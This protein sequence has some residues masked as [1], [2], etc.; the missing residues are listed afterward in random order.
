MSN[1][2]IV[3][4]SIDAYERE[5]VAL[6]TLLTS[7]PAMAPE[8]GG[9]GELIKA[10]ALTEWLKKNG[11]TDIVRYDAK[12]SRV[13]SGIRPN[14]V[15]TIKGKSDARRLW[16][17]SHLDVVP[18]GDRSMW[19]SDPF[20]VVEKDGK[21]YGRGVEDNQQGLVSGVFAALA[22]M[23][24]NIVP[25]HTIK[26]LFVADE[27]VGSKF[28]IQHLLDNEK[29]FQ[30]DD[31]IIIPDGGAHDSSEIEVAEKNLM[32]LKITTKGKQC[33]GSVPDEGRNAF[34]AAC[35]LALKVNRL[36][37]EKFNAHNPLFNPDRSTFS[38]TKKEAN[39]PNIN[40]IPGDDVFYFDCRILPEYPNEVVLTEIK[41]LMAETE[42]VHGVTMTVE[43][44]Q[45]VESRP[46][47]KDADVVKALSAAVKE[48]YGVTAKPI[49]IGGGTVGAY[50]RNAGYDCVV[51]SRLDETA[52]Q[53]NECAQ[54]ANIKGD[55]RV[56]ASLMLLA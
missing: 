55:A 35:D 29:L 50:L 45:A 48:V 40:T 18:E 23:R 28:G 26:L 7:I 33:H 11:I 53:P 47:P 44:A 12:D 5:I 42:K 56:L 31:F 22:L 20:T 8:S 14:M 16:I 13:E 30:K 24:N 41:R 43:L 49:G 1:K 19:K 38:P 46:T 39:V 10:E 9:Q 52:H 27:E 15:A 6:E 51:W 3:F 32:W 4:K 54:L 25:E 36:D 17:M 37:K 2:E 34:L 21:L